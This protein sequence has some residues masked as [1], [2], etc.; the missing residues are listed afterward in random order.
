MSYGYGSGPNWPMIQARRRAE[1]EANSARRQVASHRAVADRWRAAFEALAGQVRTAVGRVGTEH[2]DGGPCGC[3][4]C[5]D[6]LITRLAKEAQGSEGGSGEA[7]ASTFSF[8]DL[9][10]GAGP[11]P[12]P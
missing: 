4:S 12:R 7:G 1:E 10:G 9:F 8:S 2:R 5:W 11:Q 6:G 3:S